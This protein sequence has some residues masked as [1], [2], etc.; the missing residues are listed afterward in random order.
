MR[1]GGTDEDMEET[2]INEIAQHF[3]A[4]YWKETE[5]GKMPNL[6]LIIREAL[7]EYRMRG[8]LGH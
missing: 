2:I 3:S 4:I 5:E 8:K 7:I 1:Y 6:A